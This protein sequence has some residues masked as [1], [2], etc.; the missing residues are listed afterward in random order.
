MSCR[1]ACICL[2]LGISLPRL[3]CSVLVDSYLQYGTSE[4]RSLIY[5][6]III[7]IIIIIISGS[8]SW[9]GGGIAAVVELQ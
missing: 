5:L 8:S 2:S 9:G 3:L 4:A 6:F 7:I 1:L